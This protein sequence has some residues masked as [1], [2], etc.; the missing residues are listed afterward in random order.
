MIQIPSKSLNNGFAIPAIG[1]GTYGIGGNINRDN[2]NDDK[3]DILI[4]ERAIEEGVFHIDTAELYAET[5]TECLVG[6]AIQ[7]FSREK[8]FITSKVQRSHLNFDGIKKAVKGSLQRL[9]TDYLDLY[10]LHRYPEEGRLEECILA[11]ND[12]VKDGLIK[13]LG[14][15]NFNLEHTQLARSISTYPIVA[16]QVHYNLQFRESETTG[17]LDYCQK[18]DIILI[19]YRPINQ[20]LF[21]KT[22]LNFTKPGIKLLDLLCEKYHKTQT[23]IAINWLVNQKNVVT[24]FKTSQYAHLKENIESIG[25]SLDSSDMELLREHF[26]DQ[27]DISDNQPLK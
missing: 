27:R 14:I 25:W 5:Y 12:L 10:L 17:L 16:T 24:I 11:M 21:N 26:P 1:L 13:N 6:K 8:L 22:G 9:G 2:K 20:A 18:N 4:I 23:Q 19:A 3:R 15:S 7:K